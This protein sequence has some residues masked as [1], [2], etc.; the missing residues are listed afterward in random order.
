MSAGGR[1]ARVTPHKVATDRLP[2]EWKPGLLGREGVREKNTGRFRAQI[3]SLIQHKPQTLNYR[4]HTGSF[5][6]LGPI[7]PLCFPQGGGQGRRKQAVIYCGQI[8]A[9]FPLG[10]WPLA[11]GRVRASIARNSQDCPGRGEGRGLSRL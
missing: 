1:S 8:D 10:F 6:F 4:Q 7:S 5:L 9:D 3:P 11:T 2:K